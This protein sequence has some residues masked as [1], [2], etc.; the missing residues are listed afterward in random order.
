MLRPDE[1]GL[2]MTGWRPAGP[3]R[4]ENSQNRKRGLLRHP[5]PT[6]GRTIRLP[7]RPGRRQCTGRAKGHAVGWE[8]N[9]AS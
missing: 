9:R 3:I 7:V 6:R 5:L 2:S 1:F 8:G 4:R